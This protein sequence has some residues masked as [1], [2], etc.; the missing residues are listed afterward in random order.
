[1][2][3]D[4]KSVN[5]RWVA[6]RESL[7][8]DTMV[9]V[10]Q[11]DREC[12]D[13]LERFVGTL[14]LPDGREKIRLIKSPAFQR[15]MR[16]LNE[17][18]LAA[19]DCSASTKSVGVD[20]SQLRSSVSD[21]LTVFATDSALSALPTV[22]WI[23]LVTGT[24]VAHFQAGG[25]YGIELDD[26]IDEGIWTSVTQSALDLIRLSKVNYELI[27]NFVGYIVPLKRREVIQNLSFSTRELPNVIFKNNE[28]SALLFGEAL[29]HEADHQFFYALEELYSFWV[30]EPRFQPAAY[31]SP[32]RDDSR[33]LDGI[34]RGL[35]AFTR[36]ADYYSH[37]AT[38]SEPPLTEK[39][40]AL[41]VQRVAEC[42]D[43]AATLLE[44]N[45]LSGIGRQY[46]LE[47]SSILRRADG[48]VAGH[49]LYP[50][51]RANGVRVLDAHRERWRNSRIVDP[52]AITRDHL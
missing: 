4:I 9:L 18:V 17:V 28:G 39:A 41:L 38:A 23:R 3:L 2:F 37:V 45:E 46:V 52:S 6:Q 25:E 10:S 51:W 20:T 15:S 11:L 33:P 50:K 32:W 44:A 43:G 5:E 40:G 21:L 7:L 8:H 26:S 12:T 16:R 22:E 34:L 1:M 14:G 35:S 30:V 29:V 13:T 48:S 27:S 24:T 31:H 19:Y 49:E 36:V 47:L 42:E